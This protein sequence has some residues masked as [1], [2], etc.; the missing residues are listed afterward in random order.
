MK[1]LLACVCVLT[2]VAAGTAAAQSLPFSDNF[3]PAPLP[4]YQTWPGNTPNLM[5]SDTNHPQS[6]GHSLRAF[7]TNPGQWTD[8]YTMTTDATTAGGGVKGVVAAEVWVWDD[9]SVSNTAATPVNAMLAFAGNNGTA[10]PGF[11]TDYAEL[12]IISGNTA[13]LNNWVIRVRGYDQA[14]GTTWFDTG[15]ARYQ[16]FVQLEIVADALPSQGGDG[17]YHF[18]INGVDVTPTSAAYLASGKRNPATGLE[19]MRIGSNSSTVQDFWYDTLN[20][21]PVPEPSSI[22]LIGLG[23]VG[24]VGYGV[25]RRRRD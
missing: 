21:R 19:W 24:L 20:V 18:F 13:S 1:R 9:N 5:A 7:A 14:N 10:T 15:V 8:V 16:G 17:L 2:L 11:G 4:V 25:R 12:G 3:D 6:D 22:A 23:L